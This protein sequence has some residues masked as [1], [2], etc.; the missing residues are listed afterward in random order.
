[1]EELQEHAAMLKKQAAGPPRAT[2][3]EELQRQRKRTT[4]L[5]IE[6]LFE[7]MRAQAL[8]IMSTPEAGT[9]CTPCPH[10]S[11]LCAAEDGA[12]CST[13]KPAKSTGPT[14]ILPI[15]SLA[16]APNNPHT[17]QTLHVEG[18]QSPP[19]LSCFGQRT[20]PTVNHSQPLEAAKKAP[21]PLSGTSNSEQTIL[22]APSPLKLESLP[23]TSC[24]A[25]YDWEQS[26]CPLSWPDG[27]GC[28][29]SAAWTLQSPP[30][31][32]LRFSASPAVSHLRSAG[33]D[34]QSSPGSKLFGYSLD[35]SRQKGGVD[36][37]SFGHIGSP[38]S[39]RLKFGPPR[40]LAG[41]EN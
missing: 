22:P 31:E 6:E 25:T 7:Y 4:Y 32:A 34:W 38:P 3:E 39:F 19:Q 21:V 28:S 33:S 2:L 15:M 18:W 23:W 11:T 37:N 9:N 40:V 17:S 14:H 20:T 12:A 35:H 29:Q 26:D 30:L 10:E 27:L 8:G 24:E 16:D 1:M 5:C 41:L 13:L 36:Q